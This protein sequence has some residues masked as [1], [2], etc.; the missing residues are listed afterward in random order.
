MRRVLANIGPD[1]ITEARFPLI[2]YR[3]WQSGVTQFLRLYASCQVS[4]TIRTLNHDGQRRMRQKSPTTPDSHH[5]PAQVGTNAP[6]PRLLSDK[7]FT[8]QGGLLSRK[9]ISMEWDQISEKWVA[10]TQRLRND[11]PASLSTIT[12]LK[13]TGV[14]IKAGDWNPKDSMPP[15]IAD[16]YRS[17][18]SNE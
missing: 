11:C 15:A 14:T 13:S 12:R 2:I 10:M 18:T 8:A 9:D 7:Q 16:G 4:A 1:L 17:F 6:Q 3:P 5:C